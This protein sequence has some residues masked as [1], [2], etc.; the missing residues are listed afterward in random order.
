MNTPDRGAIVKGFRAPQTGGGGG[1][2]DATLARDLQEHVKRTTAPYKY[3]P[4]EI[5][6]LD[7]LPKTVSGKIR[8]VELRKRKAHALRLSFGLRVKRGRLTDRRSWARAGTCCWRA[9]GDDS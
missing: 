1:A 8:R 9:G 6:F 5:E 3:Y 2:K 4:R 7:E